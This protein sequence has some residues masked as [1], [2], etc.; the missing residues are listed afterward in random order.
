MPGKPSKRKIEAVEVA[1]DPTGGV[2]RAVRG[3]ETCQK[4]AAEP[5]RKETRA[6]L[7]GSRGLRQGWFLPFKGQGNH[8][9]RVGPS[10]NKDGETLFTGSASISEGSAG[11]SEAFDNP[12]EWNALAVERDVDPENSKAG[13]SAGLDRCR[14]CAKR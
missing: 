10:F 1:R 4:K 11:I 9:R 14:R 8:F 13:L 7:N 3:K 5:F 12:S 2:E 6:F